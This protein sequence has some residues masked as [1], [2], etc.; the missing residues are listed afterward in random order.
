VGKPSARVGDNHQCPMVD[1]GP[2]PHVGG[3]IQ[4]PCYPQSR[5]NSIPMARTTDRATCTG[6]PD[7]IVTGSATVRINGKLAARQSDKTMHGGAIT[8][9][10]ANVNIG[11]PTAGATL[12][13]PAA[14]LEAGKAA[15]KGRTSGSTQQS[16]QNCGVESSRQVINRAT[17]NN[18]SEDVLLDAA[19]NNG[20]ADREPLRADSGGTSPQTRQSILANQGVQ[21]TLEPQGMKSVQQGV[22]EGRGVI[23][24]HD[25]GALWNQPGVTGG[26][27]VT[28]TGVEYNANGSPKT[29]FVN[30]TGTGQCMQAVPAS[31]FESSLRPGRQVNVTAN[32]IW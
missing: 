28:V 30:D 8:V 17:G 20:W 26:H 2:K 1:P 9:G 5:A 15:A 4:P 13:N 21:S 27:A 6:P 29:V 31:Q 11:G 12:G 10:S 3:P 14:G 24:S 22:A 25:A 32:P 18:V 16:Y 7:F 23:T 19:M